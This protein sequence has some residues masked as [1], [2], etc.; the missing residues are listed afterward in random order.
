MCRPRSSTTTRAIPPERCRSSPCARTTAAPTCSW[1][2]G[3]H[4][5]GRRRYAGRSEQGSGCGTVWR[6]DP[7]DVI[8]IRADRRQEPTTGP[9]T[10]RVLVHGAPT[11]GARHVTSTT[12]AGAATGETIADTEAVVLVGGKGTRLRPLTISA[13]K[14]MLPTAG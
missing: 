10:A 4:T 1:P 12:S 14:P 5:R 11:G 13:P 8:R 3:T 2:T 7:A 6:S 9:G